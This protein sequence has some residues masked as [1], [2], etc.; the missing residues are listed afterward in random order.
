MHFKLS[1]FFLKQKMLS[2]WLLKRQTGPFGRYSGVA[3]P[4]CGDPCP[5]G[6]WCFGTRS[7]KRGLTNDSSCECSRASIVGCPSTIPSISHQVEGNNPRPVG[8]TLALNPISAHFKNDVNTIQSLQEK[9]AGAEVECRYR[10]EAVQTY[11][12]IQT[13][14][15][16]FGKDETWRTQIM[17][18]FCARNIPQSQCLSAVGADSKGCSRFFDKG[19]EGEACRQWRENTANNKIYDTA[20]EG[21][22]N[23]DSKDCA[24]VRRTLDPVYQAISKAP[25]AKDIPDVCWVSSCKSQQAY[26]VPNSILASEVNCPKNM[27]NLII[28][29]VE[30]SKVNIEDSK[31][32]LECKFPE[33]K[34]TDKPTVSPVT[35][36]K[37]SG[38]VPTPTPT[39]VPT[40]TTTPPPKKPKWNEPSTWTTEIWVGVGVGG[41]ALIVLFVALLRA[42]RR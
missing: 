31:L 11:D 22:C 34:P 14:I 41:V 35:P 28:Q 12:H 16:N 20:I 40:V 29:A 23:Y 19:V 15:A 9:P 13:W 6:Q 17:P 32:N 7:C 4:Y 21:Y 8:G 30:N 25:G 10:P 27:C 18:K 2:G 1:S 33:T 42:R 39:P 38:P 26:L 5:P 36:S 24:C 3:D 37:T